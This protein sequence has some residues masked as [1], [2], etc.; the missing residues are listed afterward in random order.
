MR[1][2][3]RSFL[4]M[5]TGFVAAPMLWIP[6]TAH[7]ASGLAGPTGGAIMFVLNGGARTQAIFNGTV[8][9]G[10]QPFGNLTSGLRVPLSA[11]QQGSG[12]DTPAIN[13]RFNLVT[14]AQHHNRT[15]NHDTGRTVACTGFTPEE[16]KPGLLTI[17]NYVFASRPVPCVSIGNDTPTT[18]IGT[19]ISSTYSPVKI[20]TPLNVDDI[21]KSLVDVRVSARELER[22]DTLRF[23]LQDKYLRTTRYREPGDIPFFQR[24]AAEV[25]AQFEADALNITTNASLG[26]YTDNTDVQ[27]AAL[28][29]SFGVTA[30]GGGSSLGAQAMLA[31]RL[32]QLGSAGITISSNNWDFHS[33]EI[34]VMPGRANE[35]GKC[36]GALI[37]HM[38]R[39]RDPL[40]SGK[41]LLDTTV[42]TVM[43]D[44]NRGNWSVGT[45]F[46]GNNGS[47]HSTNED[48][49]AFQCIPL[50]GGGLPGGK[51]LG[52]IRQDGSPD[53]SSSRYE[54]RQIISTV[55]DLLGID[56]ERFLP[57]VAKPLTAELTA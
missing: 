7:A 44:F 4:K 30:T 49:T 36:M 2:K 3:R 12:L 54:T 40:S 8:A 18:L 10:A 52:A 53:G 1:I 33:G 34:D 51:T 26:K 47:D 11:L 50:F 45:G 21:K 55:L 17:L 13:Q 37:D 15:G 28:R 42:V 41:T 32:R 25:G 57:G 56:Y 35:V 48:K 24:R 6:R 43:T 38:S 27:N 9:S 16:L 22:L 14:T 39:I 31:L 5:A 46:N 19:E 29:T 20:R 23:G